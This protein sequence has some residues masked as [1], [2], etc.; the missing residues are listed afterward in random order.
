MGGGG[1]TAPARLAQLAL[2]LCA[3]PCLSPTRS[4]IGRHPNII[5]IVHIQAPRDIRTYNDLYVVFE[6]MDTDFSKLTRDDTQDLTVPHVRYFMYQLLLAVKYMHSAGIIHRYV[7]RGCES[8]GG[9][10]GPNSPAPASEHRR[11]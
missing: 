5:K 6:A 8:G 9:R 1:R 2:V 11:W 4:F 3:A 10:Q 7:A